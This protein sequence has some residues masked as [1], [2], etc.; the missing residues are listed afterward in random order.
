MAAK[1][2]VRLILHFG[3]RG[4]AKKYG[5]AGKQRVGSATAACITRG[6]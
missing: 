4:D 6:P 2:A 1:I 5:S 3:S